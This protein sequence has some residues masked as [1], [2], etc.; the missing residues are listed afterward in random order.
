M[1]SLDAALPHD[2][3]D[4]V[5]D[6]DELLPLLRVE[7]EIVGVS[8][9][10]TTVADAGHS[11]SSHRRSSVPPTRCRR[12]GY[13]RRPA[14][15]NHRR[16]VGRQRQ[17][18]DEHGQPARA[19][20]AHARRRAG[21]VGR[22]AAGDADAPRA[23]LSAPRRTELVEQRRD[24]H[25]LK[26]RAD[27]VDLSARQ[28]IVRRE[29][30]ALARRCVTCLQHRCLQTAEAEIA[31]ARQVAARCDRRAS[32]ASSETGSRGRRPRA[33]ARSISRPAGISQPEQLGR[34]CRRP[35]RP[36]HRAC[37]R[38]ARSCQAAPTRYRL[39]CPPDTTS[40]TAGSGISPFSRTS[41]SMCPAR[42]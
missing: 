23:M 36:R 7:P 11:Q 2:R 27:V 18:R 28:R 8:R 32:A 35:P 37:G 3:G 16:I 34:P 38:A 10:L 40:T 4:L 22:H 17:A 20:R 31:P 24:H 9:Q 33:R 14:A 29:C 25:A 1:P 6:A 30:R 5:G 26:A 21:G 19:R 42:W 15:R 13:F 39:V 12:R 41:D